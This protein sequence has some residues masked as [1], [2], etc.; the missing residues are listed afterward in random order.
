[1]YFACLMIIGEFTAGVMILLEKGTSRYH[2]LEDQKSP[3]NIQKLLF[4][5][6][7]EVARRRGG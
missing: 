4:G 6:K 1:M 5:Q 7:T 2:I 3:T